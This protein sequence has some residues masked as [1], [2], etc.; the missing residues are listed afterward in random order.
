MRLRLELDKATTTRLVEH[1]AAQRRPIVWQAEVL[2]RQAL[3]LPPPPTEQGGR[4]AEVGSESC[5]VEE[6]VAH[7]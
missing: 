6:E 3:N 5:G 7:G 2:L 1:A 4:S